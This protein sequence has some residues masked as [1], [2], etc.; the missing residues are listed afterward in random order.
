[1]SEYTST[2]DNKTVLNL[3]DNSVQD[4]I[5]GIN[6]ST[7]KKAAPNENKNGTGDIEHSITKVS[8]DEI[9]ES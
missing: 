5:R 9:N 1:M 4:R 6:S 7:V 3:I 2:K 8:E